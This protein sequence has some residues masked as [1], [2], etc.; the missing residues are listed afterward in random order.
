MLVDVQEPR[1]AADLFMGSLPARDH[2]SSE[3]TGNESPCNPDLVV[4]Q[5][6]PRSQAPGRMI[7]AG[8]LAAITADDENRDGPSWEYM[9][10]LNLR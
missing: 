6:F 10:V 2:S 7:H 8:L 3:K 1:S 4:T 5:L 9:H